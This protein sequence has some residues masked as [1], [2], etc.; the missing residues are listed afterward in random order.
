M[1]N[2]QPKES[3]L[4]AIVHIMSGFGSRHEARVKVSN[5]AGKFDPKDNFVVSVESEPRIVVGKSKLSGN[6][7]RMFSIG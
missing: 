7:L 3:G 2:V 6:I 5:V 4:V 1:V